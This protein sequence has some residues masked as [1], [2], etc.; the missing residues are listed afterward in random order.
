M[1][2]QILMFVPAFRGNLS[3]T[4]F[5]TSHALMGE[6]MRKGIGGSVSTYSWPDIAELRNMVLSVWYDVMKSSS[7]IL[8]VDDDMGFSPQ[9]ILDMLEFDE[10]V[11]GAIYPMRTTPRKWVGSGIESPE[12]RQGFINVEGVG[13]GVLLIRRDAITR[14]IEHFPD[15]IG[16]YMVL[17]DMKAAGGYRTLQFFDQI[18]TDKG[19]V[20]EDI[21]FCRRWRQTGGDVWAA[22]SHAIQHVGPW[23]FSGCFAKE[24]DE[25]AKLKATGD[26]R[27]AA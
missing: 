15:L 17:E 10:P 3:A 14:M 1:K 11:V 4:V 13:A 9:L 27:S 6:L 20:S 5:E 18:R 7:H 21:S 23:I 19:K 16:D 2:P 12:Y 26:G 22:T 25:E 8:F 24:R